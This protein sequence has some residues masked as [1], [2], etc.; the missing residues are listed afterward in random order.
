MAEKKAHDDIVLLCDGC[1]VQVMTNL[2]ILNMAAFEM[3]YYMASL[4]IDFT[5]LSNIG[6]C[7]VLLESSI[8]S[9]K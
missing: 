6:V 9:Q 4:E 2:A 3:A 5:K 8:K 7:D 1:L